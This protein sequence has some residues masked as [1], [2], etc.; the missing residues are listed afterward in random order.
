M[1]Y[2]GALLA[3]IQEK[4]QPTM[5][6]D[7]AICPQGAKVLPVENHWFKADPRSRWLGLDGASL[8]RHIGW[9]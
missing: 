5:S 7:T 6:P 8:V 9:V 4:P 1:H 3:S 2:G